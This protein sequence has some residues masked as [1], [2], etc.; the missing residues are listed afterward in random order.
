MI[1]LG[2]A[3]IASKEDEVK[4]ATKAFGKRFLYAVGV[5][6]VVWLVTFVL[7]IVSGLGIEGVDKNTTEG[8]TA[9]W[10][11]YLEKSAWENAL[12]H[13]FYLVYDKENED[14]TEDTMVLRLRHESSEDAAKE[15]VSGIINKAFRITDFV[16]EFNGGSTNKLKTIKIIVQEQ[17]GNSPEIT[18]GSTEGYR[19][20]T[21]ELDY[22]KI[23]NL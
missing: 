8:W 11:I 10:S 17:S 20:Y 16:N 23:A 15:T 19:E 6:A 5:F 9:C 18:E 4:K 1:D 21:Y 7:N 3:V 13:S 2:K 12:K 22:S 14:N